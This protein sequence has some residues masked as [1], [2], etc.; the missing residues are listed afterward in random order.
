VN[1]FSGDGQSP[2]YGSR[3]R[4]REPGAGSQWPF[5]ATPYILATKLARRVAVRLS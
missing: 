1:R 3:S 4:S 2:E 5:G